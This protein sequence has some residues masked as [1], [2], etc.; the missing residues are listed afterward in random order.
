MSCTCL[1]H[2]PTLNAND[3]SINSSN[4]IRSLIEEKLMLISHFFH[5]AIY[6]CTKREV[7][8][9]RDVVVIFE[10]RPYSV[11]VPPRFRLER[12]FVYLA[13]DDDITII[14]LTDPYCIPP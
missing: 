12:T 3:L 2:L 9:G 5:A 14:S 6:H 8:P 11:H 1:T 13:T 7:T 10:L 4:D